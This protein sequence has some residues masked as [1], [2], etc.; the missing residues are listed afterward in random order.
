MGAEAL[1]T[2]CEPPLW[3]DSFL[4]AFSPALY[5]PVSPAGRVYDDEILDSKL[6]T[7]SEYLWHTTAPCTEV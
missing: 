7:S 3:R 1:N 5:L 6:L 4:P 2:T